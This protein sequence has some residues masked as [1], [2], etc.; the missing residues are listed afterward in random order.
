[1]VQPELKTKFYVTSKPLI[2]TTYIAPIS[3]QI[4]KEGATFPY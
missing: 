2:D 1:M 4:T 3:D